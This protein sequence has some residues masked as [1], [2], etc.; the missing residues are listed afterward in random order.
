MFGLPPYGGAFLIGVVAAPLAKG[1]VTPVLKVTVKTT[2]G[3]A[4][5]VRKWAEEAAEGVQDLAAEARA[6]A[7]AAAGTGVPSGATAA[8]PRREAGDSAPAP[9]RP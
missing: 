5:Q 2:V 9:R 6:D 3:M 7:A 4:L 8:L 1:I